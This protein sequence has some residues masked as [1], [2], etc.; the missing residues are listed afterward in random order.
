MTV[1]KGKGGGA[2]K[3]SPRFL[4]L[5]LA[6][7][8]TRLDLA[9]IE[10]WMLWPDDEIARTDALKAS[11]GRFIKD[12]IDAGLRP[13]DAMSAVAAVAPDLNRIVESANQKKG[14]LQRNGRIAGE[15]LYTAIDAP[16]VDGTRPNLTEIMRG[17]ALAY[18]GK[19]ADT[20]TRAINEIWKTFRPVSHLWAAHLRYLH[21]GG[22][23]FPCT[24]SELP[25][26][27][28]AAD[29]FR[30][31][32]ETT[33]SDPRSPNKAILGVDECL[34]LPEFCQKT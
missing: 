27:L 11:L 22:R 28:Y 31:L 3:F 34:R 14:L 5:D 30:L 7:I 16:R 4:N 20:N 21:Q 15:I 1:A 10:C 6:S 2:R 32:G 12:Q 13:S 19:R 17:I 9:E 18:K 24:V 29:Q 33:K 26:L 25:D 8:P 23:N